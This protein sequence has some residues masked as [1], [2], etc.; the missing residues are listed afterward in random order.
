MFRGVGGRGRRGHRCAEDLR[1]ALLAT[2]AAV[3]FCGVVA[4]AADA[5]K[6]PTVPGASASGPSGTGAAHRFSPGP[7]HY[8]LVGPVSGLGRTGAAAQSPATTTFSCQ[9]ASPPQCYS[10]SEIRTAYGVDQLGLDG[11]G[12]TIVIVDAF[13]S[14][15]IDHDLTTFDQIFGLPAAPSFTVLNPYGATF[16]STNPDDVSWASEVTLDVEWA[17]AIAPGANIDLVLAKSDHDPDLE[18]ALQYAVSN[19]LGSVMSMSFGEAEACVAPAILSGTHDIFQTAT[20]DGMTLLAASGDQGAAFPTCDNSSFMKAVGS[21]ASDPLVT[22]VGGTALVTSDIGGT[23]QS[24]SVWNEPDFNAAGGGGFSSA[25]PAP[26]YQSGLGLSSRGVPDVAYNAAYNGGVLGVWSS[27][28]QGS[29]LVF[30]FGGTSAGSP[31]W[32]GLVALADQH[33]GHALGLLNPTLY[34]IASDSESYAQG[35][36]DITTGDNTYHGVQLTIPGYPATTGWDP[37]TGLG[38]PR[39]NGLVPLLAGA[40]LALTNSGSPNPVLSGDRLTYTVT[41]TNTG[42]ASASGA[43]ITDVLPDDA[44]F[45]SVSSSQGSCTRSPSTA[46]RGP[47]RDGGTVTCALGD[48]APGNANSATVTIV[49]TPTRPGTMTANATLTASNVTDSP[50]QDDIATATTTVTGT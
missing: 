33:A 3:G 19:H 20:N 14:P 1:V 31:Q 30:V 17:H 24:E 7:P 8:K 42:G 28:G 25:Y 35:F 36:H 26:S 45:D 34:R 23:Y 38:S 47:K 6:P 13:G 5:S 12:E 15:T 37:A 11:T 2:L 16:D 40:D 9:L 22:G 49:V 48:V 39:A 10:P 50:D 44:R 4:G 29:D 46:R 41:A 32:A 18:A 21:P 27:S 43:K